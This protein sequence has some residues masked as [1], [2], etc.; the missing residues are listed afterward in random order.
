MLCFQ[1]IVLL[2]KDSSYALNSSELYIDSISTSDLFC[3]DADR[4][5]EAGFSHMSPLA[6]VSKRSAAHI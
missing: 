5:G 4:Q 6:H 3:C 2:L 1:F